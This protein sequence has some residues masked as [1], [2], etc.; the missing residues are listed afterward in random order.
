M[1]KFLL[2]TNEQKAFTEISSILL[3]LS[4]SSQHKI[5]RKIAREMNREVVRPGAVRTAAASAA[6]GVR[7][8]TGN[9]K[10]S[11]DSKN[12]SKKKLPLKEDPIS[13]EYFESKEIIKIDEDI[14]ADREALEV[15]KA[16]NLPDEEFSEKALPLKKSISSN[17]K[18]KR[19]GLRAFR[20][21][22]KNETDVTQTN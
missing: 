7:K 6:A 11:T 3:Q 18:K 21:S 12:K 15:L 8:L 22:K 5:L 9:G 16:S 19:D 20:S 2:E 13:K 10:L 17:S 14:K 4:E 1:N